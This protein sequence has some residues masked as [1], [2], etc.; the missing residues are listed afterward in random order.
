MGHSRARRSYREGYRRLA[1]SLGAVPDDLEP[2]DRIR[3]LT[4]A[5]RDT[6]FGNPHFYELMTGRPRPEYDPPL[7]SRREAAATFE[8][9]VDAVEAA[10]RQGALET[11]SSREA[12]EMLWAAGHGYL[13][14]VIQG[15]QRPD[16]EGW[17]RLFDAVVDG[18]RP[19]P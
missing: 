1:V 5:Y 8:T 4:H 10:I 12:A 13:S 11:G 18:Y 14:L 19:S 3:A 15:L 9:L 17:D 16:L 2:L 6:A 7:D